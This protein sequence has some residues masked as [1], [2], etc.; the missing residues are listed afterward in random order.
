MSILMV[1]REWWQGAAGSLRAKRA[2]GRA[3]ARAP[4][5]GQ[6]QKVRVAAMLTV[7]V[8]LAQ[9]VPAAVEEAHEAERF[10]G[11]YVCLAHQHGVKAA[12]GAH[13]GI[14]QRGEPAGSQPRWH[15]G[16]PQTTSRPR[17]AHHWARSCSASRR[18]CR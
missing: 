13:G 14:A 10:Q 16:Q 6:P 1:V 18:R 7:G 12:R 5:G 8:R 9:A 15:A 4:R 11:A 17:E 2:A 3:D